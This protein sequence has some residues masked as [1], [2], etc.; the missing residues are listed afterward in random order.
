MRSHDFDSERNGPGLFFILVTLVVVAVLGARYLGFY[1]P[2]GLKGLIPPRV[3]REAA[4]PA[5]PV[6]AIYH[7]HTSESYAPGESH[8]RGKAGEI[9]EVGKAFKEALA[10]RGISAVHAETV[11]DYPV[12]K[13]A[14]D[15]AYETITEQLAQNASVKMVFDLHR[16]GLPPEVDPSATTAVVN[17]EKV[18]KVAFV[19]GD[20]DN[21]HVAE[22]LAFAENLSAKLNELHPGLSRGVKV[23]HG[24]FNLRVC[25]QAVAVFIGSYP[26]NTVEEAERAAALLADAVAA[27]V[28]PA[29]PVEER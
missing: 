22:N 5:G 24:S 17:G 14:F 25:P 21:P 18:A 3:A 19:V 26:Q 1:P 12:F 29:K 16:D 2:G 20:E 15:N 23:Q 27:M 4:A 9:V 11:H 8:A 6:V 28:T 10:E 13:D 7:T